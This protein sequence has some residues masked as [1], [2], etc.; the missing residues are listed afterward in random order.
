MVEI[1]YLYGKMDSAGNDSSCT[2]GD[3]SRNHLVVGLSP[4]LCSLSAEYTLKYEFQTSLNLLKDFDLQ[5]CRFY[6]RTEAWAP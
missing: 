2:A 5:L 1:R 3:C 6:Y 4:V